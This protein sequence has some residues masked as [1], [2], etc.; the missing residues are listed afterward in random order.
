MDVVVVAEAGVL[1]RGDV[2]VGLDGMAQLLR[3]LLGEVDE[4]TPGAVQ[5][6]QDDGRPAREEAEQ[7]VVA[8][9]VGDRG[10]DAA[11]LG[12]L[13][14]AEGAAVLC[15]PEEGGAKAAPRDELVDGALV[16]EL[17]QPSGQVGGFA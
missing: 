11:A 14:V 4:R 1:T 6:L 8:H 5:A 7:L 17:E 10:A 9:L 15:D 2:G 13:A 12:E 16:E 3:E